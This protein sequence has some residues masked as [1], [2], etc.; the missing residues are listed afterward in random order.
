MRFIVDSF[1]TG[2]VLSRQLSAAK[3]QTVVISPRSYFVFTSLLNSTAVGTLEFRTALEP[4]RSRRKPNVEFIQARA[5]A[6]DFTRKT[7]TVEQNFADGMQAAAMA[8][9]RKESIIAKE[10]QASTNGQKWDVQYDKLVVSVGCNPQTF[11]IKGVKEHAFFMKDVADARRVR[12]R[13]LECFEIASLPTTSEKTREQLMRFAVVGGGPTGMEFAAELSD[14]VSEDLSKLY[15]DLT[16]LVEIS[17]YDVAE[18]V[19]SMFDQKLRKYAMDTFRREGIKIKTSYHVAELRPG[20][21]PPHDG[22]VDGSTDSTGCFTLRTREEG[23]RGVGFCVW[24]T[25]NMMNPFVEKALGETLGF[26]TA[27]ADLVGETPSRHAGSLDQWMVEKNP[28]TGTIVVD[29]HLRVQLH[30]NSDANMHEKSVEAP[31]SPRSRATMTDVFAIGD[32]ASLRTTILPVTAQTANQQALWLGTH[33]NRGDVATKTFN[34]RNLGMLTYV[35]S[36]KA[37][38]QSGDGGGITGRTAWLM[39]RGVYLA[40]SISWRNRILLPTYWSVFPFF[41]CV[42]STH[43]C[44]AG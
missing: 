37:L 38:Y 22:G 42:G 31:S 6:V 40:K 33:L 35:G 10:A 29:D 9:N 7:V 8:K 19:L 28:R 11:R 20:L 4:I 12:K 43:A 30:S 41:V 36:W 13:I 21:P 2:F 1:F 15:P 27:S 16:P 24:S 39:W 18:S 32:N 23:D 3:Y 5:E 14:L 26:P 17:V 34:F 44:F 25:G